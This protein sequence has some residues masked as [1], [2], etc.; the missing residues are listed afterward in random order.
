MQPNCIFPQQGGSQ[1][2][3]GLGYFLILLALAACLGAA[4][5]GRAQ[6]GK[7]SG[8][9]SLAEE[10]AQV[11]L[12]PDESGTHAMRI[13]VRQ[14]GG[15]FGIVCAAPGVAKAEAGQWYDLAFQARTDSRKTYAL[16]VSLE[17]A[18]GE[19][20]AARTTL[21]EVGGA[22]WTPYTVALHVRQPASPCR[23]VIALADTGHLSLEDVA[24]GLRPGPG[25]H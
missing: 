5:T 22:D 7:P 12:A 8:W 9:T 16:T 23:L 10:G 18:N 4:D 6:A 19:V 2:G 1:T 13:T 17:S 3:P 24:F 25:I 11:E 20:V 15:R 21:P 14:T